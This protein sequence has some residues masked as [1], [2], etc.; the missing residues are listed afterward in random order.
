M[1]MLTATV[2]GSE[3]KRLLTDGILAIYDEKVVVTMWG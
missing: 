1:G 3:R 2:W